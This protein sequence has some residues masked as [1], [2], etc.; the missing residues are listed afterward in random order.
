M[1]LP[2]CINAHF[3]KDFLW[4][5][6]LLAQKYFTLYVICKYVFQNELESQKHVKTYVAKFLLKNSPSQNN[7]M[8]YLTTMSS[9]HVPPRYLLFII[10]YWKI[11]NSVQNISF[12][13]ASTLKRLDNKEN[14]AMIVLPRIVCFNVSI[15]TN[16]TAPTFF[17][18]TIT[19]I[20]QGLDFLLVSL[21]IYYANAEE[22]WLN[23]PGWPVLSQL[24]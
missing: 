20:Q 17:W 12:G 8:R 18:T 21:V 1:I 13:R 11:Q 6:F 4:L 2:K 9:I 15:G 14:M 10:M 22:T 7:H 23:L 16:T 19:S 5:N 3:G 24:R